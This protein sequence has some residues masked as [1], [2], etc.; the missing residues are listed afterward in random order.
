MT[1]NKRYMI[2]LNVSKASYVICGCYNNHA[3]AVSRAQGLL[4]S[5]CKAV[6]EKI[7]V[8]VYDSTKKWSD[9]KAWKNFIWND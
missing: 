7:T 3:N 2:I 6:G 8:S 1:K 9:K 5:G 4:A